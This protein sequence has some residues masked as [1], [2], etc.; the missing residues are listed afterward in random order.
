MNVIVTGGCGFIGSH[1]CEAIAL[2]GSRVLCIDNLDGYYDAK[3]KRKN[4]SGIKGDFKFVK[5]DVREGVRLKNL[6]SRFGPD[7]VIHAAAQP[8]V[9]ASINDPLKTFDVNLGGMINIL[10][11][12]EDLDVRKFIFT[13]SSSVYGEVKYLPFDEEHPT[14]P[15]S[16]YGVSKLACEKYLKA[17]SNIHRLKYAT[18]RYFS[19]YGPRIRPD[20]AIARFV[21][22]ALADS[23]LEIYGD[24]SKSRDFTYVSDAVDAT[25]KALENGCGEYNIGG[26]LELT[27]KALAKKVIDAVGGGRIRYVGDQVGEVEHTVADTTKARKELGWSPSHDFKTGLSETIKW[28]RKN[29]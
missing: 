11:I 13:S 10:N 1:I 20:L 6:V 26:G 23:E 9:R 29:I 5:I 18:L 2:N 21:R 16:P 17:F 27:V 12:I 14:S 7:Y 19:V 22:A 3:I 25:L 15:L 24:G 4:I 8:G 28:V